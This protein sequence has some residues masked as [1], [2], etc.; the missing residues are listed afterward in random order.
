M[1]GK[2]ARALLCPVALVHHDATLRFG[3]DTFCLSNES[4]HILSQILFILIG[5]FIIFFDWW[6]Y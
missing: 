3:D 4:K 6:F 2:E 5:D 1:Q